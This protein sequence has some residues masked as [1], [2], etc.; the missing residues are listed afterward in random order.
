[1]DSGSITVSILDDDEPEENELFVVSL[2]SVQLLSPSLSGTVSPRLGT[3]STM[4]I[5]IDANDGTRGE[6][7]FKPE[8]VK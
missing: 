2:D 3:S 1:M 4:D 7:M 8:S 6:L 5:V